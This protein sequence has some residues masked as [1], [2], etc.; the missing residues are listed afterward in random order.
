MFNT[1]DLGFIEGRG[2]NLD[3]VKE[4]V[5]NFETG[6]PFTEVIEA[7]TVNNG[8]IQLNEEHSNDY[9]RFF[10]QKTGRRHLASEICPASGAASRMFKS[11][12]T[13]KERLENG[14]PEEDVLQD[15]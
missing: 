10:E 9:I 4:Q 8:I 7:A 12:F 3:T 6:F 2:S 11:L 14:E 13:A 15:R 1:E 5:K